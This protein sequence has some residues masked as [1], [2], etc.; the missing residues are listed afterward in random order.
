ML[1]Y[2]ATIFALSFLVTAYMPVWVWLGYYYAS[3]FFS[4]AMVSLHN[5]SVEL[6]NEA[7]KKNHVK[8]LAMARR[9]AELTLFES[10]DIT[11]LHVE[12][13]DRRDLSFDNNGVALGS[14][15]IEYDSK[16]YA[17]NFITFTDGVCTIKL[18]EQS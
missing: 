9:G 8:I 18:W 2:F 1:T 7:S 15:S 11:N 16:R 3:T 12:P 13:S 10:V 4:L 5:A 6:E 14:G 17:I